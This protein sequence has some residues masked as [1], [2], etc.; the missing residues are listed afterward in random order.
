M[1]EDGIFFTIAQDPMVNQ[2]QVSPSVSDD[3]SWYSSHLGPRRANL[4][5][6][7]HPAHLPGLVLQG[8]S[9]GHMTA[10]KYVQM[11]GHS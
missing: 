10:N 9:Q 1:N 8:L 2:A 7:G 5:V 11:I 3:V 6:M 4:P